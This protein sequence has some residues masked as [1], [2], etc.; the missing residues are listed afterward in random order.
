[1]IEKPFETEP[2]DEA[3]ERLLTAYAVARLDPSRDATDR[4][5]GAVMAAARAQ[6]A[7]GA[8]GG[9]FF[10][11][12]Q[13]LAAAA[14]LAAALLVGL[15]GVTLAA[16]P[17]SPFYGLRVWAEHVTLP[18]EANARADAQLTLLEER[19]AEVQAASNSGNSAG[20]AAALA[21]YREEVA[22]LLATVDSD[23]LQLA[24]LEAALGT[25]IVALQTLASQV[26]EQAR[27]AIQNAIDNSS[28]AVDRV[29]ESQGLG[30]DGSPGPDASHGPDQTP[31]GPPSSPPA[32]PPSDHPSPPGQQ[33]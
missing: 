22:D 23:A 8:G 18:T 33:P 6:A 11:G 16:A 5:R 32:G 26:P 7:R 28:K 19:L 25:H 14:L 3:V 29:H 13:R 4:T 12:R 2:A 15:A 10:G 24:K 1:V 21:A 9:G 31:A 30:P 20:V 17:G 27:D